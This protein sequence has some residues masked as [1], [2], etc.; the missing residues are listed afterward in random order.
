MTPN[1]NTTTYDFI[2][3]GGGLQAGLLATAI[4]HYQPDARVLLIER[5]DRLC[6]NHTWSF[7]ASDVS[8]QDSQWIEGLPLQR[9][10]G[11]S[12][13]F[14]GFE[15]ILELAYRSLSS[16]ALASK[17]QEIAQRGQLEIKTETQITALAKD[18]V[19]TSAGERFQATAIIDCRGAGF[20]D[21]NAGLRGGHQ[22]FHGFEI[23]L[24]HQDWP[25]E[26]PVL[27]DATI[28]QRSGFRFLYVLP[29][30]RRRVLLEDTHFSSDR[31]LPRELSL[32]AVTN[33][34]AERQISGWRIVREESGCLPM[35]YSN[36][37]R[38][39]L[40][41]P[42]RGGYAGGWFHAATG[43]SFPLAVQFA[44]AV[45]DGGPEQAAAR[46]ARLVAANRFQAT[47]A[48]LLNRLLYC[49]VAPADQWKIFRRFY[50]ILPLGTI[51][52]FYAHQFTLLD[53][54]RIL[55]GSPWQG[56]KFG[57]GLRL[58]PLRFVQSFRSSQR[59][60]F[61]KGRDVQL[62]KT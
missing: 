51:K 17:L 58:T 60:N 47:F 10:S 14:D 18:S 3:A 55:I 37:L 6:G 22:K 53:A 35:P 52:R 29:L 25:D 40:G 7:H 57:F 4:D 24:D 62:H 11:Y 16:T 28:D 20:A 34:L 5:E 23:E 49:L 9:W 54:A 50:R 21:T 43:Y 48:R 39:T 46:L 8:E 36:H 41:E 61:A 15:G 13:K 1:A 26:R 30:T 45:V 12:V 27:M 44:S 56:L 38:P 31:G 59:S 33:Y 42:V 19:T 2:L 32:L